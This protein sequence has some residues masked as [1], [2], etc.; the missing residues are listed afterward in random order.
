MKAKKMAIGDIPNENKIEMSPTN[1]LLLDRIQLGK[2][3][4]KKYKNA[5]YTDIKKLIGSCQQRIDTSFVEVLTKQLLD[6][7]EQQIN[8]IRKK[9]WDYMSE[10]PTEDRGIVIS[11]ETHD[12]IVEELDYHTNE[13]YCHLIYAKR[14]H[15]ELKDKFRLPECEEKIK[16]N[17]N[18]IKQRTMATFDDLNMPIERWKEACKAACIDGNYRSHNGMTETRDDYFVDGVQWADEHPALTWEDMMH[19]HKHLKDAMNLHLYELQNGIEGQKKVYQ[20]VLDRFLKE[21]KED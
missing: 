18:P 17:Y 13:N 19:I 3:P 9:I 2:I 16:E 20:N 14:F 12:L 11:P 1:M 6:D 8:G 10:H 5:D 4:Y 21:K 15:F 7:T